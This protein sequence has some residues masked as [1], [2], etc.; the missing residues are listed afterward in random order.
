MG[1]ALGASRAQ[2]LRALWVPVVGS[3]LLAGAVAWG[4]AATAGGASLG[5]RLPPFLVRWMPELSPWAA[6]AALG[7]AAGVIVAPRLRAASLSPAGFALSALALGLAL[8]LLLALARGGV[9][10]L[11]A[12]YD[13]PNDEASNEYLPALP[14]FAFGARTFLDT[15]AEVGTAL[16][17]HAVGHPPGLLLMLHW[18]GIDGAQGMAA[19][20]IGAGALCVPLAY[21]LG[22]EL[23]DESRARTATLLY[24]FA[25]S[26]ILYG[27][28]SADALFAT[29]GMLA[30]VALV[31]RRPILRALGPPALA[32]ASFFSYANLA[33][34]AFAVLLA[35]RRDGLRRALA[36][37][38][39]CLA[40]LVAFYALLHLATGYNPVGAL[41]SVESVYREGVAAGR[42]YG[43][44]LLGSPAAFLLAAGLPIA[45]LALRSL[46]GGAAVAVALFAVVGIAA[47]LGF[48]KAETERIYQFLV[49]L[50]C[51]AAACSLR[52]SR[53]RA[54]LAALAVQALAV[55]LLF[56]T[57]W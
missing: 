7:L 53:L 39:A 4:L 1:A 28:T 25:P 11:Y 41:R 12:V 51:V 30:A 35:L 19:L 27:A 10:D 16:P 36:L 45:W 32:L 18:L 2:R 44:W 31:A 42:P 23:L 57:V 38:V 37:S 52:E 9:G 8:R 43:Y 5:T 56:Y 3:L 24:V 49:P 14:A 26:A 50:L 6:G 13:V 55:Q 29:V 17:V 20:T 15:F 21:L 46:G 33:V 22:R 34:G 54:V 48:S 40:A 47:V